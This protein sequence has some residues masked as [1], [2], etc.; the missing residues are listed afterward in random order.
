M[1]ASR[2]ALLCSFMVLALGAAEAAEVVRREGGNE[3]AAQIMRMQ[4]SMNAVSAER[5][6]LAADK[7]K[8][9]K[10]VG[11]LR[12]KLEAVN[13]RLT[14]AETSLDRYR[15]TDTALRDRITEDR[16]RMQ[17]LVD[18]FRETATNLRQVEQERAE[19]TRVSER[20]HEEIRACTQKNLELYQANLDLLDRYESKGVW[21]SLAQREPLTGLK[22][23]EIENMIEE[24]RYRLD[25]LQVSA[26]ATPP[27]P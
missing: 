16:S 9:E 13:R 11:T 26:S 20:Q 10:D 17:E 23:V 3:A 14:A 6:A 4:Q 8:L 24:Y 27:T 25:Q 5:D 1:N 21:D 19:L 15:E 12:K 18:K 22:R 7:A 2:I